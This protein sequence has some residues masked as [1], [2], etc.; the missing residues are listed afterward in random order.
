MAK[1]VTFFTYTSEAWARMILNPGDRTATVRQLA[2]SLGG[3]V[4]CIYWMFGT[5]EVRVAATMPSSPILPVAGRYDPA[6]TTDPR[7][8]ERRR[9]A[10]RP[11][12]ARRLTSPRRWPAARCSPSTSVTAASSCRSSPRS[13]RTGQD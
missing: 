6:F 9:P 8:C 7:P 1:Y 4:E 13:C 2:D 3:S 10:T 5:H 12:A 11:G